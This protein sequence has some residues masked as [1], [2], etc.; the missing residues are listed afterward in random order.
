MAGERGWFW[1][2]GSYVE[3]VWVKFWEGPDCGK[4]LVLKLLVLKEEDT[5]C[6]CGEVLKMV[7]KG[8]VVGKEGGGT[9]KHRGYDLM[10]VQMAEERIGYNQVS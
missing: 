9:S 5:F 8:F 10:W 4:L 7:F 3:E 1:G 6:G 2:W